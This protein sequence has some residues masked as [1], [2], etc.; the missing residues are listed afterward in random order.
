MHGLNESPRECFECGHLPVGRRRAV[1]QQVSLTNLRPSLRRRFREAGRAFPLARLSTVDR[2]T[3]LQ[4]LTN[5]GDGSNAVTLG[6]SADPIDCMIRGPVVT[7]L[8]NQKVYRERGSFRV[9][10][11]AASSGLTVLTQ[12]ATILSA[13]A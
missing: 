8:I 5:H 9:E 1:L 6:R 13:V 3:H 10:F 2:T 11:P 7:R 4:A 12:G